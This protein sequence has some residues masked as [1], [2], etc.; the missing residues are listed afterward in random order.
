M[1]YGEALDLAVKGG[2]VGLRQ[3]GETI[4]FGTTPGPTVHLTADE[5]EQIGR[6]LIAAAEAARLAATGL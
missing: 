6:S 3:F 5:A 1:K 2:V 4:N